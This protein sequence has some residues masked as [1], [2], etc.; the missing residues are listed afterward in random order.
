MHNNGMMDP[1]LHVLRA[2]EEFGTVTG[3]A[4]AL[5]R[6]PSGVSRQ[7]RELSEEFG[8]ALFEH[9]GRRLEFTDAGR[10]LLRYAHSMAQQSEEARSRVRATE[11]RPS[12]RLVVAG[13]ISAI[14]TLI[15]P[16][17]ARLGLLYD[18]LGITAEECQSKDAIPTLL[19]GIA[20]L[21]VMPVGAHTPTV[22]DPRC[23][24]IVIGTEPIDLL[25]PEGHRLATAEGVQLADAAAEDWIVGNIGTDSRNETNAAC[26]QAGFIPKPAHFAQDWSAVAALVRSGLGVALVTRSVL[27]NLYPGT[28]RIPLSGQNP[29]VRHIVACT[30]SGAE[31]NTEIHLLIEELRTITQTVNAPL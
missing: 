3:A 27:I 19:S 8:V 30:R 21:V 4:E 2:V 14:G 17:I 7:L 5:R 1:R 15:G 11:A 18:D 13:H 9:V 25:V 31:T 29:P 20:D 23:S 10:T 6:S 22:R 12:G 16:A 24:V 26:H 28:V